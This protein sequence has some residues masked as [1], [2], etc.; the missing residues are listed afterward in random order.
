MPNIL[1]PTEPDNNMLIAGAEAIMYPTVHS[2]GPSP[3]AMRDAL[4]I[5]KAM[6][7]KAP[8]AIAEGRHETLRRARSALEPFAKAASHGDDWNE[9][10]RDEDQCVLKFKYGDL[11]AVR[12]ALTELDN[13]LAAPSGW[14]DALPEQLRPDNLRR[15]AGRL[16]AYG[17][18][19][20]DDY[21]TNAADV[22]RFAAEFFDSVAAPPPAGAEGTQ[23]G[24]V[25]YGGGHLEERLPD[26]AEARAAAAKLDAAA[27]TAERVIE[28]AQKMHEAFGAAHQP[29][30]DNESA[31]YVLNDAWVA[32]SAALAAH[33]RRG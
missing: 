19:Q 15:L 20:T 1:A 32:L 33:R 3:L 22:L 12:D 13:A 31:G 11:R 8:T 2:G 29:H 26:N 16:D 21:S 14:R 24:I 10:P 5:Y 4:R 25:L 7:A 18:I 28:A 30:H 23:V 27:D 6:I 17:C 9:R